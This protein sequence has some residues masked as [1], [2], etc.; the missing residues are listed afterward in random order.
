MNA[1]RA[2]SY[3]RLTR[4]LDDIGPAKLHPDEQDRVRHAADTLVFAGAWDD[5]VAASLED[6]NLLTDGLVDS[7]RWELEAAERLVELVSAC[8]PEE[9]QALALR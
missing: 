5:A 7:G 8:G 4:F 6:L 3:T 2:D 1:Q 9:A